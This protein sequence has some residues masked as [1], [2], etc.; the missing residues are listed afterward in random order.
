TLQHFQDCNAAVA[1][2]LHDGLSVG[3][4]HTADD[5]EIGADCP[6]GTAGPDCGRG[7]ITVGQ[8][9]HDKAIVTGSAGFPTP[10]GT[11]TFKLFDNGDCSGT[12]AAISSPVTLSQILAPTSLAGGKAAAES[13]NF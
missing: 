11:V 1:T 7:Y 6:V 3:A 8:T 12:P 10:T 5:I 2:E 13:A 4:A 9:I